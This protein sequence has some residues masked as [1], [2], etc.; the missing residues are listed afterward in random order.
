MAGSKA[1]YDDAVDAGRPRAGEHGGDVG[2]V[3]L[4]AVVDAPEH[5]IFSSF[6]S[7]QQ[8]ARRK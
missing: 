3:A 7:Q 2:G 5:A 1:A 8:R 6:A 4:L